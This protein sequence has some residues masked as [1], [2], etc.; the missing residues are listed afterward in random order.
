M[1]FTAFSR[2]KRGFMPNVYTAQ[3]AKSWT[4]RR[5]ATHLKKRKINLP[6]IKTIV[7]GPITKSLC[8]IVLFLCYLLKLGKK[9]LGYVFASSQRTSLGKIIFMIPIDQI[10]SSP[11]ALR[12][13]FD[14][15]QLREMADSIR[16]NGIIQPLLV[17]K[18]SNGAYEIVAGERRLRA[19]SLA[20]C[21][22]VPCLVVN[23]DAQQATV[24]AI[25][26]NLQRQ[27]L[28]CFEQAEG[29]YRLIYEWNI[30]QEEAARRLGKSQST[31]NNKMRLLQLSDWQRQQIETH[32]LSERHAR[33]LLRISNEQKRNEVLDIII[34]KH[35]NVAQTDQL[36]QKILEPPAI[37]PKRKKGIIRDIR[38]FINTITHAVDTMQKSG[39]AA[40]A[41]KKETEKY[42]EYYVRIPKQT[43][44]SCPVLKSPETVA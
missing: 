16:H 43:E 22:K 11:D 39:V 26:E 44:P 6:Y 41:E 38:L 12:K 37:P 19:A 31:I 23:A 29:F 34:T 20:G 42:I 17:R 9:G 28:S 2:E 33:A 35:L 7:S 40:K 27:D 8:H 4:V 18:I 30:S 25:L 1:Y 5:E 21:I 10:S 15:D 14:E 3:H 13:T 32:G 24:L 36:I